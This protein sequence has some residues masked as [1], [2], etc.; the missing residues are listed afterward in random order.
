[1]NL[2]RKCVPQC[3][4][5]GYNKENFC[6]K[7]LCPEAKWRS[8]RGISCGMATHL[9]ARVIEDIGKNRA[10]QQKTKRQQAIMR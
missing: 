3:E 1:M 2:D 5:C 9:I 6:E 4:P 10:G 8:G 7:F